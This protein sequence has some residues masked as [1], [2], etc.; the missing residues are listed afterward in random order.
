MICVAP[1]RTH[2]RDDTVRVMHQIKKLNLETF[3]QNK[4]IMSY[5]QTIEN[6][7]WYTKNRL[8]AQNIFHT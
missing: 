6:K 8:Q 5:A 2:R 7:E 4:F 1:M 3:S